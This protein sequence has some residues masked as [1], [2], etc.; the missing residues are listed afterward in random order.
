MKTS[1]QL[2]RVYIQLYADFKVQLEL[3]TNM[4]PNTTV[5]GM[6]HNVS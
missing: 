6:S 2:S 4:N 5:L 1:G 3:Y